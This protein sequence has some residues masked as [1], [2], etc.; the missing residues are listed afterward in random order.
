MGVLSTIAAAL[1][2]GNGIVKALDELSLSAEERAKLETELAKELIRARARILSAEANSESWLTRSWRPITM[3]TFLVI[4]VAHAFG[5]VELEPQLQ[6]KL[7]DLI[8]F[9][10]GGY[11]VGRSAEKVLPSLL[12]TIREWRGSASP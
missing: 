7:L 12:Q 2:I 8:H 4:I 5:Y 10:L 6:L 9:G 3:M 11:I 1:G